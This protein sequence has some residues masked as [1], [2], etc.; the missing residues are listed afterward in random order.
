MRQIFLFVFVL[1]LVGFL[2]CE[3]ESKSDQLDQLLKERLQ[4]TSKTGTLDYYILPESDDYANLPNQDPHNPVTPEKIELGKLLFFETGLAQNPKHDAC[5]ET[6]SCS[7]CHLP[8]AGFLPGRIQGIADGGWGYGFK[9]NLRYMYDAYDE[10]EI[11]AQGTRPMNVLNSGYSTNTLWSGLFGAG[12][13]NEGTE[14]KWTGL[15]NVNHTGY[16]GLEAQNIE[17]F[18]LHRLDINDHLL[19][20]YG[21]RALFDKAFPDFPP[22]ERYSPTTTS[23]AVG[24]FLRSVLTNQ[25][26]FQKWLKGDKNAMTDS[27]KEGAMLFFGK[28]RCYICHEGT[29]LN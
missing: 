19:D 22:E 18:D 29:A 23:F 16:M 7:S 15:A 4:S 25:A 11:D 1:A 28:A 8:E 27:Q 20:D 3:P 9:G 24:A 17:A 5:Y 13:V 26:P 21:Y 10:S 6:Y 12:G 14:D 2:S